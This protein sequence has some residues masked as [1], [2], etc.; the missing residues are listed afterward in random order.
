MGVRIDERE[1]V[2]ASPSSHH[3]AVKFGWARNA[4]RAAAAAAGRDAGAQGFSE[5]DGWRWRVL[6]DLESLYDVIV[7]DYAKARDKQKSQAWE[8][9]WG[10]VVTGGGAAVGSIVAVLGAEIAKSGTWG[11]V[12]SV[13]GMLFAVGGSVLGANSYVRNR[14]RKLRYL[15]LMHALAD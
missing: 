1:N 13:A 9:R 4:L 6:A 12:L 7:R 5:T 10:P 11:W 8:T 14:S 15:H 2:P 3:A